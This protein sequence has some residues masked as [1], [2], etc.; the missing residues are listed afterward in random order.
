MSVQPPLRPRTGASV[1]A[2]SIRGG[3]RLPWLRVLVVLAS[4]LTPLA[5]AQAPATGGTVASRDGLLVVAGATGRTGVHVVE[6]ALR[7][8]YQVRVLARRPEAARE[9]FGNRVQ[10][11]AADVRDAAT[12]G[13]ALAGATWVIAS[14]GSSQG[15]DPTYVPDEVEYQGTRRLVEAAKAAGVRHF[16]MITAMGVTQPDHPLNRASRNVLLW[17]ALGENT[18]RFS[19]LDYTIVR[20]GALLDGPGGERLTVSQGDQFRDWERPRNEFPAIDRADLALVTV[21]ALGRPPLRART[22]EVTSE[23]VRGAVDWDALFAG[24]KPDRGPPAPRPA[25]MAPPR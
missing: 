16:V 6:H 8:G 23:R 2:R 13:P 3:P 10:I 25:A 24:L 14:L 7:K 15:R 21:E 11:V 12:L 19:G 5:A 1:S 22:F 4:L 20:P 17:K 18:L 9:R